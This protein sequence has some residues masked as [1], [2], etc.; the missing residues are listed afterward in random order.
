M[1]RAGLNKGA[2]Y[3]IIEGRSKRPRPATLKRIS[4]ALNGTLAF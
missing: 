1:S 3:N 2:V 4:G